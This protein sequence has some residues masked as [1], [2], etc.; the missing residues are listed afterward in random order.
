MVWGPF[1]LC[2]NLQYAMVTGECISAILRQIV[3]GWCDLF[4]LALYL[5]EQG[6][7]YLTADIQ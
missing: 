4:C 6:S 2:F 3:L 1:G 7:I 5:A